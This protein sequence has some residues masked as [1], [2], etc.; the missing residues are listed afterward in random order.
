MV[1]NQLFC[2]IRQLVILTQHCQPLES[3]V[4]L[5]VQRNFFGIDRKLSSLS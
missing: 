1:L 5:K 4:D 3:A 2:N